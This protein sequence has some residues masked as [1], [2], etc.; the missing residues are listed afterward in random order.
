M[1]KPQVVH[2]I[3]STSL[4][5]VQVL[6]GLFMAC[7]ALAGCTRN[8]TTV[9]WP[10]SFV[11]GEAALFSHNEVVIAAPCQRVWSTLV[12]AST[13]PSW[14]GNAREVRL[15][16]HDPTSLQK[17]STFTWITFG[18]AVRSEVR[19]Y[20]PPTRLAWH[21]STEGMTA[22]HAWLLQPLP[23]GCHVITEETNN[24]PSA[25]ALRRTAPEAIHDGHAT[26]L[27]QLKAIC[28]K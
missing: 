24:G 2:R 27:A 3:R 14:Y 23:T 25:I 19:E 21:G 20:V 26:W 5:H 13:W 1:I 8:H 10:E 7:L 4:N 15:L 9:D 16:D 18:V 22:Y 12:A 11:P 6:A 28:E 17:N